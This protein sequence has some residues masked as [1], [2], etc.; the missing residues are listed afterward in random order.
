MQKGNMRIPR[1]ARGNAES[2]RMVFR[3]SE[4]IRM[5]F[6]YISERA[7]RKGVP[8][9][10]RNHIESGPQLCREGVLR[11]GFA[12]RQVHGGIIHPHLRAATRSIE[13]SFP[14]R[15]ERF[16]HSTHR[17]IVSRSLFLEAEYRDSRSNLYR[18]SSFAESSA[19]AHALT[20]CF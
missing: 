15:P 12:L 17:G 13:L 1:C 10:Y 9:V 11:F 18:P 8:G 3:Q 2:E 4:I 6:I 16:Q 19:L 20:D 14:C 5:S 7:G